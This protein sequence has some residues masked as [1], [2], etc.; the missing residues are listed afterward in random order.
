MGFENK[1]FCLR[2]RCSTA[3]VCRCRYA[4]FDPTTF[5]QQRASLLKG[6]YP[7][8]LNRAQKSNQRKRRAKAKMF[9]KKNFNLVK[10][11][12]LT[13]FPFRYPFKF[14]QENFW[15]KEEVC[16]KI[17][18]NKTAFPSFLSF[19][20][21][22]NSD[23]IFVPDFPSRISRNKGSDSISLHFSRPHRTT[24]PTQYLMENGFL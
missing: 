12:S 16:Q 17:V 15:S 19:D 1:A 3:V 23:E 14:I 21:L 2:D 13:F 20:W 7:S 5:W 6:Y 8:Q 10:M 18:R 9:V 24:L 22:N 4:M 11:L